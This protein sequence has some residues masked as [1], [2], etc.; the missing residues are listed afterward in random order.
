MALVSS[1]SPSSPGRLGPLANGVH[2]AGP[3]PDPA[4][5]H[6]LRGSGC[7]RA[8]GPHPSGLSPQLP[9]RAHTTGF[10][11]HK[12]SETLK[13]SRISATVASAL[14]QRLQRR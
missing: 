6:S 12:T 14:P 13:L 7:E 11:T 10:K 5:G 9:R 1:G 2:D 3:E 8:P 4:E